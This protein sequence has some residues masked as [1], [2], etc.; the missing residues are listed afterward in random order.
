MAYKPVTHKFVAVLNRKV[1]INRLL[2]ALGHMSVGMGAGYHLP[3][4]LRIDDYSDADSG[5][6]PNISDNPFIV[7]Q[8]DNSNQ[9]RNLRHAAKEAGIAYTDFIDT[10]IEGT[11]ADQQERTRTTHEADLEYYGIVLF[12]EIE[13]ISLLTK[14]FSLWRG[15]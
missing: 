15:Q 3:I 10:M 8:A 14:K 13:K 2:N 1:P 7:L 9:I 5:L 6:H 4:E 11:Y 12:G